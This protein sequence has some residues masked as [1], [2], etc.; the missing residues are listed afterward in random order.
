MLPCVENHRAICALK[1]LHF[2]RD[3]FRAIG[4]SLAETPCVAAI[5]AD[6]GIDLPLIEWPLVE[7]HQEPT[8][9][10]AA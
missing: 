4:R 3:A 8:F 9:V 6:R 7:R 1:H 5:V 10:R 2:V